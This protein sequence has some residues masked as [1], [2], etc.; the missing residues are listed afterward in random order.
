MTEAKEILALDVGTVRTGV[1]RASS[2]AQVAEPL[3]T[4]NTGEV[5][6]K[7]ETLVKEKPT[8]AIVIG[9]PRNLRG[10]E[11]PQTEW[12]RRWAEEA[13]KKINPPFYWQDE[14]LTS[15]LASQQPYKHG[16]EH[17][18][19]AAIVLQDFLDSLEAERVL[20]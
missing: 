6:E 8:E 7:L 11:T 15:H 14:A 19:A 2:V 13:K 5:L 20:V 17:S 4:F 10:D 12:V 1:A 9:L 18:Q 16:D 3:A